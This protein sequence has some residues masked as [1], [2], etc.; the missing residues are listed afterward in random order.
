MNAEKKMIE[1]VEELIRHLRAHEKKMKDKLRDIYEVEQKQH[2]TRLRAD[3]HPTE[4][5]L[6]LPRIVPLL[7]TL[8]SQT[9]PLLLICGRNFAPW[10]S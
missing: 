9:N 2:A 8:H 10:S 6:T 3:Y 4:K 7:T 5:P 1:S